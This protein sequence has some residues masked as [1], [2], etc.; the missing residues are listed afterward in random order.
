[1]NPK[2]KAHKQ[3]LVVVGDQLAHGVW[4][5]A[6]ASQIRLITTIIRYNQ[7]TCITGDIEIERLLNEALPYDCCTSLEQA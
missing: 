2:V 6:A 3:S 7:T 1:M 4:V 5:C